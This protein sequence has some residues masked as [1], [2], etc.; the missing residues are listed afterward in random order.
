MPA[1]A[2]LD[3]NDSET[4]RTVERAIRLRTWGRVA[5]LCVQARGEL[6]IVC[7]STQS[8]YLKQLAVAGAREALALSR[9][10]QI[11][12]EVPLDMERSR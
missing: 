2:F 10:V 7:G 12:I 5:N 3:A 9:P 1:K 8:Y 11:D 4:L 6:V